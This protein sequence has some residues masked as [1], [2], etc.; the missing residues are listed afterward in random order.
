MKNFD[1]CEAIYTHDEIFDTYLIL[2]DKDEFLASNI[3]KKFGFVVYTPTKI[4]EDK[5]SLV[6]ASSGLNVC[7]DIWYYDGRFYMFDG[8]EHNKGMMVDMPRYIIVADVTELLK[9]IEREV[10]N[11]STI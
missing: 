8:W 2:R 10:N 7:S 11:E 3:L 9:N 5:F 6:S 1:R 4:V